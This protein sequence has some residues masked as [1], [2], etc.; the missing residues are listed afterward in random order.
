VRRAVI[1]TNPA[2]ARTAERYLLAARRRLAAAGVQAEIARTAAAGDGERLARQAVADGAD[3]VIAH[4]GDGTAMDVA[5][6]LVGTGIP[7]GLLPAGTG[8]L[9]AGNLDIRRSWRAAS[10]VIARGG[11]RVIDLG[12]LTTAAGSRIFAVACGAGFDAELM[13]STEARHKR[14]LGMAAYVVTAL[15]L[16]R[17]IARSAVRVECG[18]FVHEGPAAVVLIANC[19]ELIPGL[20]PIHADVRPDDGVFDVAILDAS[21]IPGAARLVWWMLIRRPHF[22]PGITFLRASRVTLSADPDFPVQA[23][24]EAAGTTP[25]T[26]EVLPGALHVLAPGGA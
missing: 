19:G 25:M 5:A 10:D 9:L 23:D 11:T 17:T 3:L 26:V 4:G 13:R 12:R 21:S 8:N 14:T 16:A 2:A 22:V 24:G 6:A 20:L 7:L 18:D 15:H 1:V